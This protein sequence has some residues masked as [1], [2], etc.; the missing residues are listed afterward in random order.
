MNIRRSA[1]ACVSIVFALCFSLAASN[2][3]AD[4]RVWTGASSVDWGTAGNWD[5]G[6]PLAGDDVILTNAGN[7]ALLSSSTPG[8]NSVIIRGKTLIFTNWNTI[9]NATTVTIQTGGV[10]TAAGP[11]ATNQMSNL[12]FVSCTTMTIDPG[13]SIDVDGKGFKPEYG[14]GV[15][16]DRKSVV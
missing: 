5:T 15:G 11:F 10:F 2:A 16:I 12:V 4:T 6:V 3:R 7:N 8:L 14:P 13:G 1:F 9:L